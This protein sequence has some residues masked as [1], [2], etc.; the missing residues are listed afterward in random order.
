[1]DRMANDKND[2]TSER[3][4]LA[5]LIG[6][7]VLIAIAGE[8]LYETRRQRAELNDRLTQLVTAIHS[9]PA[10]PAAPARL[11]GP[12]PDKVYTVNT[13]GAPFEGPKSAA[14]TIVE[15]SDFQ[16]PFCARVDPTVKQLQDV[17]KDEVQIVWKHYPL[18]RIHQ[19]AMEAAVAAEA[20]HSQGKFWQFHDKLLASQSRLSPDQIRQYANELGLDTAKFEADLTSP[21][22]R[23]R[24][25]DD[26]SEAQRLGVAGTPAF[27]VNG[28]FLSGA[29]PLA[30]FAKVINSELQRLKLPIPPAAVQ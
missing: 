5:I 8:N 4:L 27:F 23:K 12:D 16:C 6:V 9:R 29:Q 14:I 2:K 28:H 30:G 3:L 25:S 24:I 26:M 17:Y 10:N 18:T 13:E 7:A 20:A 22:I 15:F 19:N 1:M 21:E 11:S